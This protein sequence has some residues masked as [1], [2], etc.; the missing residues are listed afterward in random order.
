[1]NKEMEYIQFLKEVQECVEAHFNG[2]VKGEVCT[3]TKNNGVTVIGLMLKGEDE[4]V[5]PNFYLDRQF[6]EWMSGMCTLEEVAEKLC[7]TYREE[8]EK[9]SHLLSKIQFTWEEFR[10]GV[11]LRLVN[12]EKNS[13]LLETIP[14]REFLDLAQIYYYHVPISE[15]VM[16][17]LIITKE[18]MEI[19]QVSE[20]ELCRT[21]T[22]NCERFQP[23]KIR[24]MEDLLY[25]L[26][27]KV[28]VEVQEAKNCHPFLFVMTNSKGS[29]G[30]ASLVFAEELERFSKR[31]GNSFYVL[32][33]SVHE[34]ILVPANEEFSVE[35]FQSMVK[36]INATQVDATEVLSDNIYFYN[37]ET[38]ELSIC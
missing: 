2:K 19:L 36:E 23:I 38:K 28:G 26:G 4:R 5:A 17:T 6:V 1:M 25:D 24:C 3:S 15:D 32:P 34:V 9:N 35:Y 7:N 16:G 18:H 20:E 10:R 21:A 22:G 33:S 37:K 29:F 27:R 11:F 8:I 12:K 14:H 31:I 13:K 30:A